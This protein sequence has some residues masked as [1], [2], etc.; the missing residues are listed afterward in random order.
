MQEP[1]PI[2]DGSE[3]DGRGK[4]EDSHALSRHW[5]SCCR[6]RSRRPALAAQIRT[7][8]RGIARTRRTSAPSGIPQA[9]WNTHRL[10]CRTVRMAQTSSTSPRRAAVKPRR[11]PVAGD[12]RIARTLRHHAACKTGGKS[13]AA[14]ARSP[15][16][17]PQQGYTAIPSAPGWHRQSRQNMPITQRWPRSSQALL[18]DPTH[19]HGVG[20]GAA[21]CGPSHASTDSH[22]RSIRC[23]PVAVHRMSPMRLA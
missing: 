16:M 22:T 23:F 13:A 7:A 15:C 5:P 17:G 6:Q 8:G 10:C 3:Q 19:R 12:R 4:R 20:P 1:Q 9:T 11:Y 14:N 2:D 21:K 18:S